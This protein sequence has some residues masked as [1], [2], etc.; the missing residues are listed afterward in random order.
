MHRLEGESCSGG[1]CPDLTRDAE[2]GKTGGQGYIPPAGSLGPHLPPTPK[3]EVRWEMDTAVF[4]DLLA[5]YLTDD[6]I[7]RILVRRRELALV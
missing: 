7:G 5:Q 2:R 3:G 4:E 1:P 6:A